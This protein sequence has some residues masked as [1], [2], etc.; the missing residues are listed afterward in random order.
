M[1]TKR[2]AEE[3]AAKL[4]QMLGT[5]Q[6]AAVRSVYISGSY[7]RGDWL[8]RSSDLDVNIVL[9]DTAQSVQDKDIQWIQSSIEKGKAGRNFPSQCPGGVDLGLI[10]EKYIPKNTGRG[11]H[12]LALFPVFHHHV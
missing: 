1:N 6:L 8:D 5:V 2:L 3:I 4:G 12:S 7:C 10:S 11:P 9:R